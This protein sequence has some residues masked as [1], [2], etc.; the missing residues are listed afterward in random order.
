MYGLKAD[1]WCNPMSTVEAAAFALY[2]PRASIWPPLY[3]DLYRFSAIFG[4]VALPRA[5]P[6]LLHRYSISQAFSRSMEVTLM[7]FWPPQ[8]LFYCL[9]KIA[10]MVH[11]PGSNPNW[12][13]EFPCI[14]ARDSDNVE[15][16]IECSV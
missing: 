14:L 1:R 7:S 13:H 6:D 16:L 3:N 4:Y 12:F 5:S 15:F 9:L 10:S 8:C 11:I 2:N